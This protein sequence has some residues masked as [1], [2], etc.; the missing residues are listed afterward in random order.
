MSNVRDPKER[1]LDQG[2]PASP[3]EG[4]VTR[5]V[6]DLQVGGDDA[7]S[8]LWQQYF[9]RLCQVARRE[10]RKRPRMV[11]DEEDI[12][13]SALRSVFVGLRSGHFAGIADR[14]SLWSFLVHVAMRKLIDARR[15]ES[16]SKRDVRRTVRESSLADLH[17]MRQPLDEVA[18]VDAADKTLV[19]FEE[20]FARLPGELLKNLAIA[21][22]QGYSSKEVAAMFDLS[23]RTI[24]R[25]LDLIRSIWLS[26]GDSP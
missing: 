19:E 9:E 14:N 20:F 10:L 21:K 22:L 25:K 23:E 4:S 3:D 1:D 15:H 13:L 6:R 12:A 17:S 5:L 18:D 8:R 11:H 16:A 7:A 24:E 2:N 26:L